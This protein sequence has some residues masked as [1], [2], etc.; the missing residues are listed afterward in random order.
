MQA[1]TTMFIK[2][3][4]YDFKFYSFI[5]KSSSINFHLIW[6]LRVW[7]S[8]CL[9]ERAEDIFY[10]P[11]KCLDLLW[12][13]VKVTLK[14]AVIFVCG[15]HKYKMKLRCFYI[16]NVF[17]FKI[18][19]K[20]HFDFYEHFSFLVFEIFMAL[21]LMGALVQFFLLCKICNKNLS[22]VYLYLSTKTEKERGR[23]Y[24]VYEWM[25]ISV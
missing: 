19:K 7:V 3:L 10:H 5:F 20:K 6:C 8:I 18:Q 2:M 12:K 4:L 13:H 11:C 9:C 1:R 14:L 17:V 16:L 25:C 21:Y 23:E 24:L 22:T 15:H